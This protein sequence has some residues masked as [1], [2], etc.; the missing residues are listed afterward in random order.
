MTQGGGA[1]EGRGGGPD[2]GLIYFGPLGQEDAAPGETGCAAVSRGERY[3]RPGETGPAGREAGRGPNEMAAQSGY[4]AGQAAVSRGK[5]EGD[6][7]SQDAPVDSRLES[8]PAPW[9]RLPKA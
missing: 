4:L 9:K 5:E 1:P 7:G 6:G 8:A 2:P 3:A